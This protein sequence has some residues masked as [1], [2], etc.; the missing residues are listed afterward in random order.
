M[1]HG[2]KIK[3]YE[4]ILQSYQVGFFLPKSYLNP[5]FF[6]KSFRSLLSLISHMADEYGN[7]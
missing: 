4:K 7:N 3:V 1:I 2:E 6:I 5:T